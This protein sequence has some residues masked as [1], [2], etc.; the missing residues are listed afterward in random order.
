VQKL[1]V[2]TG[3]TVY[4]PAGTLHALSKNNIVYEIQQA[5]DITYRFYDYDR[6]DK[7]GKSRPLQLDQAIQCLHYEN[8]PERI[9]PIPVVTRGHGYWETICVNNDSFVVR[10][11]QCDGE[12][13]LCFSGYQLV[14]V[15]DGEGSVNGHPLQRGVSF[16]LPANETI[17]I[18]GTVTLMTT[19]EL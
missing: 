13:I 18:R 4:I 5:T 14:T 3:D 7:D 8:V 19:A 10:R 2:T 15:V 16:L 6:K 11:L 17:K 12:S 9:S 1:P